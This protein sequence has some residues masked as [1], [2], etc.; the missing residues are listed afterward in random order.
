MFGFW[1]QNTQKRPGSDDKSASLPKSQWLFFW[2]GQSRKIWNNLVFDLDF[3]DA[4]CL[5]FGLKILTKN[6]AQMTIPRHW[7]RISCFFRRGKKIWNN[8]VFDIKILAKGLAQMTSLR[9]CPKISGFFLRGGQSRK[10]W[11][12]L[13]FDL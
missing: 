7:P 2:R 5:V 4:S 1:A 12:N 10:I 9:H 11:N 3:N 6:Q 8:L 13:V